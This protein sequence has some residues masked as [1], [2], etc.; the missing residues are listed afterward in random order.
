M[1]TLAEL[2]TFIAVVE[3]GSFSSAA[4]R[5]ACSPSAVS[6]IISRMESRLHAQLF[7]RTA[8]EVRP[9]EAGR[10]LHR[11]GLRAL[12]ALSEAENALHRHTE[13]ACGTLRVHSILTFAKYQLA[14]LIPE[15]QAAHPAIRIEFLLSNDLPDMVEHRIDVAIHSGAQ[16]DSSLIARRLLSSRRIVCGSPAYLARHGTPATPADLARHNCLNFTHRTHGDDWRNN[17]PFSSHPQ[18]IKATGTLG[19]DQGD[20]LM[21]L[22]L[23]GAGLVRLAEFH[24][25][26]EIAAGRLVP[27]LE[28]CQPDHEEP[29]FMIYKSRRY[30]SPRTQIFLDFLDRKFGASARP[31]RH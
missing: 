16:P 15:F 27:V 29:L 12:D 1:D 18:G 23:H 17:W 26:G 11:E 19:A 5:L 21:Q 7:E 28:S 31:A 3:T 14:P 30:L 8:R 4:R 20:M 6:K 13:S 25:H 22:A 2:R 9:T 24:I 10:I